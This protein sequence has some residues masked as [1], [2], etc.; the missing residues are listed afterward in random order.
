MSERQ[1]VIH[2]GEADAMPCQCAGCR[3]AVARARPLPKLVLVESTAG[4][5][6]ADGAR[7]FVDEG[8]AC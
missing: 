1:S 6:R 2:D 3:A 7:D 5:D 8:R 4:T